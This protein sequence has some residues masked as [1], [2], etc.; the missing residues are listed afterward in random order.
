MEAFRIIQ[1]KEDEGVKEVSGSWWSK[2]RFRTAFVMVT[3][4]CLLEL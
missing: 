1:V 3:W 2:G 4:K